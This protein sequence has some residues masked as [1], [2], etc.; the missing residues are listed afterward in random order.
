MELWWTWS[1]NSTVNSAW[2][3]WTM[4]RSGQCMRGCSRI[5]RTV[6]APCAISPG[7]WRGAWIVGAPSP[8]GRLQAGR[9]QASSHHPAGPHRQR[10]KP[11]GHRHWYHLG[12]LRDILAWSKGR[13]IRC[14]GAAYMSTPRQPPTL[15]TCLEIPDTCTPLRRN[16]QEGRQGYRPASPIQRFNNKSL[17][18]P[19]WFR[20]SGRS[21][22]FMVGTKIRGPYS[23]CPTS[24]RQWSPRTISQRS[25]NF[26]II[27]T[28]SSILMLKDYMSEQ[29]S[30]TFI[31]NI[32]WY[33]STNLHL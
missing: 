26:Y 22:M 27:G 11:Q 16:T 3:P 13:W 7:W 32:L 20:H 1:G 23:W 31:H 25:G 19:S 2:S 12:G 9:Q 8:T 28:N 15:P 30:I 18:W 14:R 17:N 10:W 29:C 33:K 4:I 21:L 24:M 6:I 5:I